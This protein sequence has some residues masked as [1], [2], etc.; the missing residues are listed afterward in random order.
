MCFSPQR[1]AI[2]RQLNFKKCS[3]TDVF[4]MFW[5][6]NVLFATA[7]CNFSTSE[8]PKVL[9]NWRGLYILTCEC[10]FRHSGVQF[11]DSWTSK[12]APNASCFVHVHFQMWFSPQRRTIFRHLNFQKCSEHVMFC[13]FSLPNVVFATAAY[14]FSTSERP[15]VL[16]DPLFFNIF[17]SKCA[18]RHSGVHFFDI[19]TSKSA[20]STSCFVHFHFKMCFSPQRRAIFDVSSQHLPPHPPL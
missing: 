15:K 8:L 13:T 20:P 14:N 9:R 17:T 16:P 12:S 18:F 19:W 1:R 10:A 5:L 2:F 6:V 11:F 7:V 4:C 3:E